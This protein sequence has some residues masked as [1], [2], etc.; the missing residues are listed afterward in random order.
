MKKIHPLL[1]LILWFATWFVVFSAIIF[2]RSFVS[3]FNTLHF[4]MVMSIMLIAVPII[5]FKIIR[6]RDN[7]KPSELM[8]SARIAT[9][10]EEAGHLA[11]NN[12]YLYSHVGLGCTI[13]K[14]HKKYSNIY[15]Q[16]GH[17]LTIAPTGSGK[18]TS[19]AVPNLLWSR[20]S[21]L[22]LDVKGELSDK[23]AKIRKER[24]GH[25]IHV[26]DP[27]HVFSNASSQYNPL[28]M[29]NPNELLDIANLI[30]GALCVS[31]GNEAAHFNE[32]A[33]NLI[34]GVCGYCALSG[35]SLNEV[36]E[37][38]TM[39]PDELDQ[40]LLDM[41][42]ISISF[43]ERAANSIIS[44]SE[45]ERSSVLSTARRHTDF[46]DDT[47]IVD[48]LSDTTFSF[49]EL[50]QKGTT[51]Y[52]I[53]P[54]NKIEHL[55]RYTRLLISSALHELMNTTDNN[56]NDDV[57]LMIDEFAQ[58]GY[59]EPLEQAI[60]IARGYGIQLWYFV[61]DISQLRG[62]YRKWQTFFSNMTAQVFNISDYETARWVSDTMGDITTKYTVQSSSK[63]GMMRGSTGTSTQYGQR[64]FA[65]PDELLAADK[66]NVIILSNAG[67]P[68]HLTQWNY[69]TDTRLQSIVHSS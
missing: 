53:I 42:E 40:V 38:I 61:Q 17:I 34:R 21:M 24:M 52:L 11:L 62:V 49:S 33:R 68:V 15:H 66:N 9:K 3:N 8:G 51:I 48:T 50:K 37:I 39:T 69:L 36:R 4:F 10:Q 12:Q 63:S 41:K 19:A 28:A 44:L 20:A 6:K 67:R 30:S 13:N 57:V 2:L 65:T 23:T 22:V 26:I 56:T 14:P 31:D 5:Y 54:P 45:R 43:I 27:F 55:K 32:S 58:L 47:N 35:K 60:S 1:F 16:R 18:G 46:L 7:S 25:D 59:F 29:N 64:K